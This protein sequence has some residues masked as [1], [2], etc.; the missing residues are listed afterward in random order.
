MRLRVTDLAS[1]YLELGGDDLA[2]FVD[3]WRQVH[4]LA[5][6][7]VEAGKSWGEVREDDSHSAL[8]SVDDVGFVSRTAFGDACAELL[9]DGGIVVSTDGRGIADQHVV[10]ADGR[11]VEDLI[12][13]V[14]ALLEASLGAPR[15]GSVPA[16]DLPEHALGSGGRFGFA[17]GDEMLDLQSHYVLTHEVLSRFVSGVSGV[18]V[19]GEHELVPRIWPHHFD[20][21]SLLV[22][23]RVGDGS[24]TRTIGVGLTPPDSIEGSGYWYVSPWSRASSGNVFERAE[25]PLGR[26]VDRGELPMAV[27]PVSDVWALG[28]GGESQTIAIAEFVAT[29]FNA[30]MDHFEKA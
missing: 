23:S 9:F 1:E 8:V 19:D 10:F 14:R 25:L 12:S 24:M 2:A 4:Y 18:A 5:Q 3:A 6:A 7:V 17:D 20:L 21:A 27:L 30:C 29:A 16:P 26:W 15:Q 13:R 22:V 28:D 11:S